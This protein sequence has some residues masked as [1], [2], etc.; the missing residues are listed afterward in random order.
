[1]A[2]DLGEL[3]GF[4]KLDDSQFRGPLE[5]LPDEVKKSGGKA[6]SEGKGVGQKMG[7]AIGRGLKGAA[8]A[9][10]TVA[11][12]G[13]GVAL[14]KGFSRL[15]GIDNAQ[16]KL[17]G[18]GHDTQSVETIMG[19]AL[20]AV[21]GTA[22]GIGDAATVAASAVAAGI[23]PGEDLQRTLSLVADAATIAGT[24]MGSMGAIF[25][26][27]AASNK[28][29]M[30]VINQLHDAG[31]PALAALADHMGVTAEEASKMASAGKIDFA[32]FQAAMEGA[33]GGAAKSSG[34]TFGGAMANVGASLGRIGAGLLGSV[35]PILAPLLQ[36]IGNA[37]GPVE[38]KAKALGEAIGQKL[39][40]WVEKL[41][42]WLEK[43]PGDLS[44]MVG[45]LGPLTGAFI[46][47]GASGFA[48]LL[49]MVPGL[50]GL[51]SKLGFLGGPL[52]LILGAIAGL[53][54]TSP[55]LRENLGQ[56]LGVFGDLAGKLSNSLEPLISALLPVLVTVLEG[57]AGALVWVV[58][59]AAGFI[60][61]LSES[62]PAVAL[63]TGAV[64]GL[65]AAFVAYKAITGTIAG[66]MKIAAAAQAAWN[67][68]MMLNPIGIIIGLVVALVGALVWF[69]TQTDVGRE[70]W[71]SFV[72]WLG[73][74]WQGIVDFAV[75]LWTELGNFFTDLWAGIT[76]GVTVA[77]EAVGSFFTDLWES[78][79]A[80]FEAGLQF[81]VDLFLN[82][83]IY[84]LI[85]Q[86]W[87][88]IVS[89]FGD[90]WTNIKGFFSDAFDWL[91]D[92][93]LNWTL[94]GLL[95]Q[96]WDDIVAGAK[97][98]WD[99]LI[100]WFKGIPD[101]I[102]DIFVSAGTWLLGAGDKIVTGLRTGVSN[103]W[104]GFISW[105]RGF[106]AEIIGFFAGAG[107][108]LWNAGKNI[109]QGLMDG[110]AS[111][112]GSI[113]NFFLNLLPGWIV[114]PFKAALGIHSPSRLFAEYGV[115]I[116]EG[117]IV[118]VDDMQPEI[119]ARMRHLVDAPAPVSIGAAVG[120]VASAT[121]DASASEAER[122]AELTGRLDDLAD[123]MRSARPI[124]VHSNDPEEVATVVGEHLR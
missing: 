46:A 12:T 27:A 69:F 121:Q 5:Q 72:T 76:E 49:K 104:S 89:F 88:N 29:Q 54:A 39:V 35:F 53:V 94:L 28:V 16:K 102:R 20:G 19:N 25:N 117:V 7:D 11:A 23:K 67:A 87:D 119:D 58:E 80:V 4:L 98:A 68:V 96:Y 113:G 112:A 13:I 61:W 78:I 26:K 17:K 79:P 95:I 106:P 108:W 56:L 37:L 57:V 83:T 42:G 18:L 70:A 122:W 10:V 73:E 32:T 103:M 15:E 85:I 91:V 40:P 64:I 74:V 99:G 105:V 116:G 38:D 90:V 8:T 45:A 86:N 22:Y 107:T 24:D 66:A 114:A 63:I 47:L 97:G 6:T 93:F 65:T 1:M 3:V 100:A 101:W 34:D 110:V 30:D 71:A 84:G 51:A 50:G 52:G 81:L 62:E 14:V 60:G 59:V 120:G 44:G 109:V 43:G 31:V 9:G 41:I 55:E 115:N 2:L 92:L 48:P 82:W 75:T 33:L 21:K 111:L 123:A 77:W 36:A 118:G 124:E